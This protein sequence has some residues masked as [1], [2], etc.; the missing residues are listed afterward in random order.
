MSEGDGES[1]GIYP[2]SQ[3]AGWLAKIYKAPIATERVVT[4]NRLIGL[5][6]TAPAA[7][8]AILRS[9]TSWPA[10][11]ITDTGGDTIG[12]VIPMAPAACRATT[13]SLANRFVEI[14]FL[15][16]ADATLFTA[17]GLPVPTPD[18]RLSVCRA[19]VDVAALFERHKLV[20]SDW[21][22]SNAFWNIPERSAF[23][24]DVDGCGF[25]SHHNIFQPNWTDPLTPRSTAADG[26]TDRYRVALLVARCL[27]GVRDQVALLH[28][29]PAIQ[30]VAV[31]QV[32]Q[33]QLLA[34]DRA[35]RPTVAALQAALGGLPYIRMSIPHRP[36]PDKPVQPVP[37]PKV[38][39]TA[40]AGPKSSPV[41]TAGSTS[42][43]STSAGSVASTQTTSEPSASNAAIAIAFVIAILVIVLALIFA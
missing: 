39:V 10:A 37:P 29:L 20:Y 12:S 27:T 34:S 28:A 16:K 18:D 15:A 8:L 26:W 3:H 4:L 40:S 17:K 2:L 41:A 11:R 24:I 1:K 25:V 6:H 36:L 13:G 43:G 32:L 30:P 21:S 9:R 31:S 22:Y 38:T 14:D 19:I 23:V 5:A 33:D 35:R 7:D 42:V